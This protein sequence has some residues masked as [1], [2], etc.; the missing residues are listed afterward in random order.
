MLYIDS[1]YTCYYILI[2][3]VLAQLEIMGCVVFGT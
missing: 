1:W 3:S 2:T